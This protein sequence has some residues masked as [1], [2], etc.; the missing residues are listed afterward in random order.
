MRE[1]HIDWIFKVPAS[2]ALLVNLVFLIRIMWVS[3]KFTSRWGASY[4]NY[5]LTGAHNQ[6]A[7]RSYPGN[8]AVL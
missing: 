5:Y 1:S 4:L 2:L 7:F 3:P 8:A 6:T